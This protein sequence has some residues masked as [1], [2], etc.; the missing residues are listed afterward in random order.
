MKG[1]IST[2]A[3]EFQYTDLITIPSMIKS[4]IMFSTGSAPEGRKVDK[5]VK[6]KRKVKNAIDDIFEDFGTRKQEKK[7]KDMVKQE[8]RFV[9]FLLFL[10]HFYFF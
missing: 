7:K 6:K 10:F 2:C 1:S 5:R 4:S 9:L 8:V 3:S